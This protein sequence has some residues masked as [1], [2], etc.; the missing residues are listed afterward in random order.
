MKYNL[1]KLD[2][3]V[4][5]KVMG[6]R[7]LIRER[8]WW[9]DAETSNGPAPSE[10]VRGLVGYWSPSFDIRAAWGVR[11]HVLDTMEGSRCSVMSVARM[12]TWVR[13]FDVETGR[14]L[15]QYTDESECVA[16]VIAALRAKGVSEDDIKACEEV[17]A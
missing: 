12:F 10:E 13:F 8:A 15:G 3:L 4:A 5:E 16:I 2:A 9:V 7:V 11:K 1:T 17:A 6:W 14:D